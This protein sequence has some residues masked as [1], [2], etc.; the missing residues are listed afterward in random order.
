[1]AAGVPGPAASWFAMVRGAQVGPMAQGPLEQL[2]R[3]GEV[4]A[5]S[6]VW[7]EG[8]AE[9]RRA[10][11]LPDL[12]PLLRATQA[13]RPANTADLS[14]LF[15]DL[16]LAV[17]R[18]MDSRA[19]EQM[20]AGTRRPRTPSI[21]TTT[22]IRLAERGR[23]RVDVDD[24]DD[25][26][27]DTGFIRRNRFR[28]VALA[29]LLALAIP[30][31]GLYA[32]STLQVLPLEVPAVDE[33]TGAQVKEPVFSTRGVRG[34]KNLLLGKT[35]PAAAPPAPAAKPKPGPV[36]K[37]AS[38]PPPETK[39]ADARASP[40]LKALYSDPKKQ[41]VGPGP[42][43]S[44]SRSM[45]AAAAGSGPSQQALSKV[46]SQ[47]SPAFQFCI[48]Q[49]LKKTPKFRGGKVNLLATVGP[50]G[51]VKQARL[52]RKEIDLSDLGD[53][54]KSKARRLVFPAFQGEDVEVQ[55]PLVLTATL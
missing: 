33:S 17:S 31:A 20:L 54:L 40:E 27:L 8:M 5:K 55:I 53:C 10:E 11:V 51:V 47:G 24:P 44:P 23:T 9:W 7:C 35:N 38:P 18:P 42:A 1:V 36:T 41:D 12:M 15:S 14:Q 37:P 50:S 13:P 21:A 52:D 43:P 29:L 26:E 16:D 2:I 6:F 34:L 22:Q 49:Q 32:L 4:T 45:P 39:V 3:V 25:A 30:T 46:V 19:V 48:E 28:K